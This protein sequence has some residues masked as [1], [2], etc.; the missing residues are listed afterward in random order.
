MVV[1]V[2]LIISFALLA[3]SIDCRIARPYV[4]HLL[5]SSKHWKIFLRVSSFAYDWTRQQTHY[6]SFDTVLM[7]Q[8]YAG[9][10]CAVKQ[11]GKHQFAYFHRS[12]DRIFPN[13]WAGGRIMSNKSL[14]GILHLSC[15]GLIIPF[16]VWLDS[17]ITTIQAVPENSKHDRLQ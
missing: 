10:Y 8:L 7:L 2:V 12:T 6:A 16:W 13:V 4:R 15:W 3:F 9:L 1:H 5:C 14:K 17:F 11:C